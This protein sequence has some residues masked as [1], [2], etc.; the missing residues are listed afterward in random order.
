MTHRIK[1]IVAL[2]DYILS[3]TFQNGIVKE[4]D[5]KKY[6]TLFPQLELLTKD[7]E[8]YKQVKVDAGGYGISW[9][10]ELDLDAEDIWESGVQKSDFKEITVTDLVAV[11]LME[12]RDKK[13]ITQKQLAERTG[14]Y[15]ADISK[16]ERGLSNPS[17]LTLERLAKGLGMKMTID[18]E[19]LGDN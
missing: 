3:V 19:D 15:Q 2:N 17:L 7:I 5:L 13:G 11:K 12:A 9:N 18:F 16:I 6:L 4:F 14:I 10:D 1:N 8:L